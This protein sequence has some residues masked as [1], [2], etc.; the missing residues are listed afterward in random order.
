[1]QHEFSRTELLI[2]S[3]GL[4]KLR[5]STIM[6]LG[7]GGVG[8]FAVEALARA[9]VGHLILVDY[10]DICLT[11]INRQLHALHSTVGEAKV[12]VMKRRILEI[13]PE[14][15]VETIKEFYSDKDADRMLGRKLDYVVDAIDTV[16]S[17]VSLVKECLHR[18]IPLISSMGAGNRLTAANYKVTD[19]SKTSGD[20]LAKAVRKL[21]RKEGITKGLKVV[22]TTDLPLTPIS[23]QAD[24][25]NNCICPSGDAHCAEKRQIPGSISFVTSVVGLLIAGEVVRDLLID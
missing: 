20:P 8:S 3:R 13:N 16:S 10:D 21:S 11:N 14:A 2:G 19:I 15:N 22:S 17:K 5:K 4:E 23:S 24:C 7:I 18:K 9:A 6:I 12:E 1:M 25:T